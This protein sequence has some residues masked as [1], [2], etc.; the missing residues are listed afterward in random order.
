MEHREWGGKETGKNKQTQF[1][2]VKYTCN[3]NPR[4]IGKVCKIILRNNY[5][6]LSQYDEHYEVV[7]PK[8]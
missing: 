4:K 8:C 6:N 1:Q 7:D 2:V 3:R 5:Q